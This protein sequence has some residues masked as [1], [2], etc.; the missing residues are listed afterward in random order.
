MHVCKGKQRIWNFGLNW[1]NVVYLSWSGVRDPK[2]AAIARAGSTSK[3]KN[4]SRNFHAKLVRDKRL[5]Q[6]KITPVKLRVLQHRPRVREVQLHYPF[7][8]LLDWGQHILEHHS[9]HMLGGFHISDEAKYVDMFSRFWA[10]Y[11]HLDPE[12]VVYTQFS[13]DQ[14]GYLIPYC[15]HGDEGRGKAKSPILITSFQMLIG[16]GGE[17][18]T[19]MKG[20]LVLIYVYFYAGFAVGE[21]FA[22]TVLRLRHVWPTKSC[23]PRHS[24]T[25]R[26]LSSV[27][28]SKSFAKKDATL[29]DI[30]SFMVD[31]LTTAF[32][33]GV[34]VACPKLRHVHMNML[35]YT[36]TYVTHVP[37]AAVSPC[38]TLRCVER[39]SISSTRVSKVTGRSWG[40]SWISNLDY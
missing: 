32:Y 28:P 10:N 22:L 11:Q 25:T 34:F 19:N 40:S 18:H 4:I 15:I 7:I 27:M 12:H 6:V 31:D 33:K 29:N 16:I 26:W 24:F 13:S 5:L 21:A 39:P 14:W 3:P 8:R 17:D 30:A 20:H 2:L 36:Q 9:E 23:V 38:F 37:V 1:I 35:I